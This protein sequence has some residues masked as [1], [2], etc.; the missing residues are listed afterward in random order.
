MRDDS[1]TQ[2]KP[3]RLRQPYF[4]ATTSTL[5]CFGPVKGREGGCM[6][7]KAWQHVYFGSR[8]MHR[9]Y[10]LITATKRVVVL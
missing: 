2:D 9:E 6:H 3:K 4:N 7:N 10:V 5:F 8:H 1:P